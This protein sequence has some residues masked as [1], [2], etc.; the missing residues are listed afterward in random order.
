[1]RPL[2]ALLLLSVPAFS[3]FSEIVTT[4]DGQHVYFT[5]QLIER[6]APSAA[7]VESRLYRIEGGAFQLFVERGSLAPPDRGSSQD[8]ASSLELTGDG[9]S[10]AFVS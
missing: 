9:Q 3:Q 8:G 7:P 1:M 6:S 5:T 10:V 2:A 4:D